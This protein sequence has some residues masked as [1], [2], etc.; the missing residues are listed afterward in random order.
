MQRKYRAAVT[1]RSR[2]RTFPTLFICAISSVVKN[3]FPTQ[4]SAGSR[5]YRD[6]SIWIGYVRCLGSNRGWNYKLGSIDLLI[7]RVQ[8]WSSTSSL[9]LNE[10]KICLVILRRRSARIYQS[11]DLC[12][13]QFLAFPYGN[14][15]LRATCDQRLSFMETDSFL[16]CAGNER[17][18]KIEK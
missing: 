1:F 17:W 6:E 2:A 8:P 12:P 10:M 4:L 15:W 18:Q 14:V 9:F 16:S 7:V 3:N 11:M 13:V 5:I